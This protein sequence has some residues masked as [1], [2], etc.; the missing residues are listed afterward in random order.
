ML[1]LGPPV[2]VFSLVLGVL[3]NSWVDSP[4]VVASL[5]TWPDGTNHNKM[6]A[7]KK[8]A[9]RVRIRHKLLLVC[10]QSSPHYGRM[11]VRG[12]LDG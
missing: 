4:E 11:L 6:R 8:R 12:C 5:N 3:L 10:P 2:P 7:G 1:Y 9:V